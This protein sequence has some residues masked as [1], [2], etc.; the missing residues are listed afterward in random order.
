MK[1]NRKIRNFLKIIFSFLWIPI[2]IATYYLSLEARSEKT[3]IVLTIIIIWGIWLKMA[4]WWIPKW[5]LTNN[6]EQTDL[7]NKVRST[8]AQIIGGLTL[9]AGLF[10]TWQS[11][12]VSKRNAEVSQ[13]VATNN[14]N[15][16]NQQHINDSFARAIELLGNTDREVRMGAIYR[17]QWI[18]ENSPDEYYWPVVRTFAAYVRDRV[19]ANYKRPRKEAPAPDIQSIIRFIIKGSQSN[20]SY[21]PQ[22]I[23]LAGVD[24]SYSNFSHA[25]I[26]SIIFTNSI[27]FGADFSNS[28]LWQADF[29]NCDL[30]YS[31]F[32]AAKL[33][34]ARFNSS[35]L[36]QADFMDTKL[37]FA[38]FSGANLKGANF[39]SAN[40]D[41]AQ[42]CTY[43]DLTTKKLVDNCANNLTCQ[44][45]A[46]L[47][48][49]VQTKFPK[50]IA[51][52]R[53]Q[54]IEEVTES[55]IFKTVNVLP[56]K[57]SISSR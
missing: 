39:H 41:N 29:S 44:Q 14:L 35:D 6:A 33:P 22:E 52:C 49:K 13:Q 32:F 7:T 31:S 38:N 19:P 15:L 28:Y 5:L 50:E 54:V 18:A 43:L 9:M 45:M 42:F 30:K 51:A 3:L 27:L 20:R 26:N 8:V 53:Y 25:R 46:Y 1:K 4:I 55:G 40:L 47:A 36:F 2:L 16:L 24:L 48:S 21:G 34:N 17:L 56:S 23:D 11:L 12:E 37:E 57:D 10:F